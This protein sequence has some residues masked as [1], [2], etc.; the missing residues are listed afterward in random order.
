V[1]LHPPPYISRNIS[2]ANTRYQVSKYGQGDGFDG[3][4][5]KTREC[6]EIEEVYGQIKPN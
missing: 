1:I 5:D 4:G 6:R 2:A 3:D